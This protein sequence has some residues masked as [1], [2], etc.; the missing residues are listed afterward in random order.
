MTGAA[1][2]SAGHDGGHRTRI[3]QHVRPEDTGVGWGQGR[4]VKGTRWSCSTEAHTGHQR[5][6]GW[7]GAWELRG[8]GTAAEPELPAVIR[9]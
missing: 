7:P 8:E 5:A 1:E 9:G 2:Q 4:K 3:S 6:T